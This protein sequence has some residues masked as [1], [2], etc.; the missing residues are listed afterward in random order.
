M[1]RMH[2]NRRGFTFVELVMVIIMLTIIGG[3]AT[4]KF[5][6]TLETSKIE[7][8]KS[9]MEAL[10]YALVGD[11]SLYTNGA[12][13]DF[14]YVGDIGALPS[15]LESLFTKPSVSY[16][17]WDGPYIRGDVNSADFK[18]DAWGVAYVFTDTIIRSTGSG[19]N[20]DKKYA[21]NPSSS[22]RG[23]TVS[24]FIV[25]ANQTPPGSSSATISVKLTYPNGT[26]S[27]TTS[28]TAP[29]TRGSFSFSSVPVGNHVLTVIYSTATD[30]ITMPICV[31]PSSTVRVAVI[32]PADL[33]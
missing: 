6:E 4:R 5:M 14:G 26:G 17:T 30:T 13:S 29:S 32:F 3:I 10:A 22:L 8:T 1:Q 21:S 28:S 7:A 9:E 16:T 2:I 25:D 12:R 18:T 20:I 33:W 15:G 24:G 19:T 23:N 31:T 27:T 11:P